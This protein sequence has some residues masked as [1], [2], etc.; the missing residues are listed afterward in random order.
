MS[1]TVTQLVGYALTGTV[2]LT[3]CSICAAVLL[4]VIRGAVALEVAIRD[5]FRIARIQRRLRRQ[6]GDLCVCFGPL[7][8]VIVH[9]DRDALWGTSTALAP[10]GTITDE[11][12][13]DYVRLP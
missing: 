6:P 13:G 7:P 9:A 5:R 3:V 8:V 10:W 11:S 12:P 2:V 4:L 1:A